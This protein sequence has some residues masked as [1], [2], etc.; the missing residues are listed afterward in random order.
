M[1]E[2]KIITKEEADREFLNK[3]E[4][5]NLN[6]FNQNWLYKAVWVTGSN[7]ALE[8]Y[9]INTDDWTEELIFKKE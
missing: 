2:L 1:Q 6:P 3:R 5:T 7:E 8:V 9:K 4:S